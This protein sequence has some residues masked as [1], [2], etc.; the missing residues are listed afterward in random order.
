MSGRIV[1]SG[2]SQIERAVATLGAK[3]LRKP[4]DY[5]RLLDAIGVVLPKTA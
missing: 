4:V 1:I 2:A 5:A 3:F